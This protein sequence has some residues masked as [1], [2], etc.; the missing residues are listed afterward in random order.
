MDIFI[1]TPKEK[2]PLGWSKLSEQ[3]RKRAFEEFLEWWFE[4]YSKQIELCR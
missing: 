4:H 2:I 3:E 1:I